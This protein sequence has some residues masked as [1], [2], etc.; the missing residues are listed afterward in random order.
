MCGIVGIMQTDNAPVSGEVLEAMT[1][2]LAHRGPDGRG[3]MLRA[4][5]GG[6]RFQQLIGHG[7][8]LFW[9]GAKE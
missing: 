7:P 9:L 5:F 2:S 1:A 4:P 8:H 6:C 3:V